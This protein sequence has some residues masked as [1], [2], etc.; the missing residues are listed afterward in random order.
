MS[1]FRA[2][3]RIIGIVY[4]L[5]AS[6]DGSAVADGRIRSKKKEVST[7]TFALIFMAM[8]TIPLKPTH[9][10]SLTPLRGI[11]AVL[12][13]LYHS[14]SLL[15]G[16]RL[17]NL[18]AGTG[19]FAR[20]Y[21]WVDFFF[22]LS[23]FIITHVYGDR[24]TNDFSPAILRDYLLARFSRIY[25]LHFFMLCLIITL[26]VIVLQRLPG[27]GQ[28][29]S[30]NT[31]PFHL[32]LLLSF[33]LVP[34]GWSIPAWSIGAEWWTYLLAL[35]FLRYLHRGVSIRTFVAPL[36]CVSG[37]AVLL[38]F[39]PRHILDIT[40]DF[41]LLR[42]FLDFVVGIC[43][44]QIYRYLF[45]RDQW[46]RRFI[47]SDGGFVVAAL[48]TVALLH[49]AAPQ[50]AVVEEHGFAT[51]IPSPLALPL[52]ALSPLVFGVLILSAALNVARARQLLNA[53]PLQYLGD[54]SYSIYMMQGLTMVLFFTCCGIWRRSHPT[55]IMD[56]PTQLMIVGI[57]VAV[58]LLLAA[59]TYRWFEIPS[60]NWLKRK[61]TSE[62]SPVSA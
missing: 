43:V 22:V 30:W 32:L 57:T 46:K 23:G 34:L 19:F 8:M 59:I 18:I 11:A 54:I 40:S 7:A 31:L 28:M 56:H 42:C 36:L 27:A 10:A 58:D 37:L 49:F 26:C 24:L 14:D 35:P 3:V 15:R 39:H 17:G 6:Q 12:V 25:P 9:I 52:D 1:R 44:Y 16:Q 55:G 47:G 62:A 29:Y 48:L 60:R 61:F 45:D 20:G 2:F 51:P 33:G 50:D 41:G 21:L 53:R 5:P 4:T 38:Y 13:I